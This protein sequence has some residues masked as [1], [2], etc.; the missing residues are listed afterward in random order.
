MSP[1][2]NGQIKFTV[3]AALVSPAQWLAI[4][5]FV[6]LAILAS[7]RVGPL[8][9]GEQT[10][11][12]PDWWARSLPAW[13]AVGW[14]MILALPVEL[15]VMSRPEPVSPWLVLIL[16]AVLLVVAGAIVVAAVVTLTGHPRRAVPPHLRGDDEKR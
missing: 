4:G 1:D 5:A 9:R 10:R 7:S 2:G 12:W 14:L 6:F 11:Q 8:W 3:V 13:I 15:L 16:G